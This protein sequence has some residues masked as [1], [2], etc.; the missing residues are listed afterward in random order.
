MGCEI[1]HSRELSAVGEFDPT[2]VSVIIRRAIEVA[3][4]R[5]PDPDDR[6][7]VGDLAAI[8]DDV[9][10]SRPALVAALAES[11]VGL[12]HRNGFADRLIGPSKVWTSGPVQLDEEDAIAVL[13]HWLEDDHGLATSFDA[14]GRLLAGPRAGLLPAVGS[15]LRRLNGTGGLDRARSVQA[16][17]AAVDGSRSLCL[18]A[19]VS[20]KRTEAIIEGSTVAG[21]TMVIIG[22]VAAV[23]SPL[24]LAA[25][26]FGAVAGLATARV[27]HGRTVERVTGQ[28]D[29]TAR[30]VSQGE[31]PPTSLERLLRSGRAI[32]TVLPGRRRN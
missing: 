20:N 13:R 19:D 22:L 29:D 15:G 25:L 2:Q 6:L 28:V 9:G 17:T 4:L 10:L 3:T 7:S 24:T 8:A 14:E 18:V 23:T 30:A 27:R 21:G 12:D 16:A 26:P 5:H 1:M 11:R 32:S 31:R